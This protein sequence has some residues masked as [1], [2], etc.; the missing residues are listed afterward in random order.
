MAGPKKDDIVMTETVTLDGF[1]AVLQPGK[2]GFSLQAIVE[3]DLVDRLE[4]DRA[5]LLEWGLAKVKNPKRSVCKPTPWEEVSQGKY[6]V[7]FSWGE[8]MKPGIVDSEGAAIT[9]ASLPLYGGSKVRLA[10]WQK[11][12]VLKDGTSYG[13]SLKLL[14]IQVIDLGVSEA[15]VVEDAD[16][17]VSN[18]FEKVDGFK[19]SSVEPSTQTTTVDDDF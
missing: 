15:G 5:R 9:N 18:M 16:T 13:T 11:P 17:D 3:S 1:Q 14:G 12:Y 7:K 4:E 8:D 6:K 19:A 2:Y 10:I